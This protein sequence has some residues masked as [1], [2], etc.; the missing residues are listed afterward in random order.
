[1]SRVLTAALCALVWLPPLSAQTP[2]HT[3]LDF[4]LPQIGMVVDGKPFCEDKGRL[5]DYPSK[6]M[7]QIIAAGP[8]A[9]PV[10]IGKITDP[11]PAGTKTDEPI[12]CYWY[13]MA[14]GDIAFCTLLDLFTDSTGGK[15][16]MP[17]AGWNGMLGLSDKRLPA[18]EQYNDFIKKRGR[19]VI[20]VKWQ[21]LWSKY[22][23]QMYWDAEERCFRLKAS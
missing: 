6:V 15:T 1:M 3:N 9:I 19:K 10:L 7:E 5:Q 2:V 4:D 18:W 12:I 22:G 14:V 17:G 20:Q 21:K 8:K 13:G 11:R 16:T 23:S